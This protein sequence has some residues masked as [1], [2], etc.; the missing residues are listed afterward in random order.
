VR[1]EKLRAINQRKR[2]EKEAAKMAERKQ[3]IKPPSVKK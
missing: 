1:E 2:D 3:K